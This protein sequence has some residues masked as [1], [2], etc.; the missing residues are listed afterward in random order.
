MRTDCTRGCIMAIDD[1]GDS[2]T[3]IDAM[4][5][6]TI[7]V[8]SFLQP[9]YEPNRLG[10][11]F[12]VASDAKAK[13]WFLFIHPTRSGRLLVGT[14]RQPPLS[15]LG[16]KQGVAAPGELKAGYTTIP[17]YTYT[18]RV[19]AEVDGNAMFA[20]LVDSSD[21]YPTEQTIADAMAKADTATLH[22]G[23]DESISHVTANEAL[24]EARK[25]RSVSG[26]HPPIS[27]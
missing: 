16:S 17:I 19:V 24:A 22:L 4:N 2:K 11:P 1:C 15:S 7:D 12:I 9:D 13:Y 3:H 14:R 20:Y 27:K 26:R 18:I 21:R 10:R 8:P 6:R 25:Q 23:I 5:Q